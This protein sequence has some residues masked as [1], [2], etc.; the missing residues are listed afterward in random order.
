M[1]VTR[2]EFVHFPSQ[3]DPLRLRLSLQCEGKDIHPL[4]GLLGSQTGAP[5]TPTS[6]EYGF[7]IYLYC[8]GAEKCSEIFGHLQ[9]IC[10]QPKAL[11]PEISPAAPT[12][13]APVAPTF[14][15]HLN[16]RYSF[17]EFV[18]GNNRFVHAAAWASAQSPGEKYNPLFLWGGAGLGK[19]HLMQAI[20][21]EVLKRNPKARVFYTSTE[22]FASEVIEAIRSGATP[23]FR[24]KYRSLDMLLID[25]IQFLAES[26]STQEEFFHT[27][28]DLYENKKQIVMTSDKPPKRLITLED[29]LK[30]RFEWGLIADMQAP[31]LETRVAILKNK[32]VSVGLSLDENILLYVAGQ[33]KNNIRE[34]E[35]F[36]KRIQ[37][38][39]LL[40]GAAVGL[41]MVKSLMAELLPP[42]EIVAA[43]VSPTIEKQRPA[44]LTRSVIDSA[45]PGRAEPK[46]PAPLD[47]TL[48]PVEVAFFYAEGREAD[49]NQ[50][51]EQFAEVIRKHSLRFRLEPAFERPYACVRKINYAFF[52][53]LCLTNHVAIA[54][55]LGPP[56]ETP[57]AEHLF[58]SALSERFE[59][60]ELVLQFIRYAEITKPYRYLSC[61]LDIRLTRHKSI[62]WT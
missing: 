29:R 38:Y 39:A 56:P 20:G 4:M 10:P 14:A 58:A 62:V 23:S 3:E 52:S 11:M 22:K 24:E 54:I 46:K 41:E 33:L 34:L 43:P 27:F 40:T 37:A 13:A 57:L 28:N 25:D 8:A 18:V 49:L 35:G 30:S 6:K 59:E 9:E 5:F 60:A 51:K 55:V 19:T 53:E 36:V 16:P 48:K 42:E 26:E 7:C 2:W 32:A 45:G 50:A 44:E 61:A 47:P 15:A 31:N 1:A 21:H 17:E 12:F